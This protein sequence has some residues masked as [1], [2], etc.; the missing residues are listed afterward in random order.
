MATLTREIDDC[1]IVDRARDSSYGNPKR[2]KETTVRQ[3]REG[4]T[5]DQRVEMKPGSDYTCRTSLPSAPTLALFRESI[6]APVN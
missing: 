4:P 3:E 5:I 6:T 2:K 1:S